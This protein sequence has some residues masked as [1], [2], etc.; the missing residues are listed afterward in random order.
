MRKTHPFASKTS[1]A[2]LTVGPNFEKYQEVEGNTKCRCH[3]YLWET[4]FNHHWD[5]ATGGIPWNRSA[6][7]KYKPGC[8]R[9]T[10]PG[11]PLGHRSQYHIDSSFPEAQNSMSEFRRPTGLR[12]QELGFRAFVHPW[13]WVTSLAYECS[14]LAL[15]ESYSECRSHDK[16]R[17]VN[18][19]HVCR[20][21]QEMGGAEKIR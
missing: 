18:C 21:L 19:M 20:V 1:L 8:F 12:R 15:L 2:P 16:V 17:D 10:R 11:R 4:P 14:R 13:Q 5:A 3:P 6:C 9:W 7:C